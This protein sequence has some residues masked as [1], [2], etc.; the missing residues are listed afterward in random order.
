[1]HISKYLWMLR[2]FLQDLP[3]FYKKIFE[4]IFLFEFCSIL[5]FA[6]HYREMPLRIILSA[7]LVLFMANP[8]CSYEIAK[9]AQIGRDLAEISIEDL[10]NIEITTA[11]KIP[12][13][14]FETPAAIYVITQE[15]IRRSGVTNIAEALRLA[16]G[17]EVARIDS[18]KWAISIRG[19]GSRLADHFWY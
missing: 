3:R 14:L 13:V 2:K 19:F 4:D 18:N 5:K 7:L 17:V 12:E 15:E 16:P 9:G 1:M 6:P 10:M 8:L 11:S